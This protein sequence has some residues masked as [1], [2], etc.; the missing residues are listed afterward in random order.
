MT[1]EEY[2]AWE[3]AEDGK[4]AWF[5]GEVLAMAGGTPR[6][7]YLSATLIAEL[8]SQ[9]KGTNCRPLT[10]DQKVH[11]PRTNSSVYPDATFLCGPA[12]YFGDSREV[13]VNPRVVVEVLSSNTE[14][15]DRGLKWEGYRELP[16]LTGYLLVAQNTPRIE[17]FTRNVDGGWLY[18]IS[19]PG[20]RV[21]LL[22]T[23]TISVDAIYDGAFD[24][25]G[26]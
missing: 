22:D 5:D 10:S 15:H 18:R 9:L 26:E 25:D 17:S 23:R 2:L 7:N 1:A 14:A 11:S 21:P 19:G 6:H 12:Q 20:D 4:H 8:L 13:I 24:L 3:R 16:S